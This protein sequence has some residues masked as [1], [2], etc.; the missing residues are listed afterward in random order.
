MDLRDII[1]YVELFY[2]GRFQLKIHLGRV[3]LNEIAETITSPSW[4]VK[5]PLSAKQSRGSDTG[6]WQAEMRKD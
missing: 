5:E 6:E 2:T 4:A 3:W 1:C